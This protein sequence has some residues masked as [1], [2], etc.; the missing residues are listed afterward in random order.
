MLENPALAQLN[1]DVLDTA[2]RHRYVRG[3]FL[4]QSN[5]TQVLDRNDSEIQTYGTVSERQWRDVV[6]AWAVGATSNSNTIT[7]VKD[8]AVLANGVGQQ[9]RVYAAKLAVM[10]AR[11]C[12]HCLAESV[13]YSD[14]FFPFTDAPQ[15]L[16]EAGVRTIITSGGSVADA[17]VI[18]YCQEKD[19]AIVIVPD[20]K[21][22]GFFGH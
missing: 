17:D 3:G 1:A 14:S 7:I 19:I 15:V 22:R 4:A 12:G 16:Y 18:A 5:Y 13:A 2:T 21:A 6:L 9:A 11:D 20:K 8:G 10:L